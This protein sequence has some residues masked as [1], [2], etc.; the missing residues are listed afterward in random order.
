MSAAT[1]Q[2][3]LVDALG[4]NYEGGLEAIDDALRVDSIILEKKCKNCCFGD[5]DG[6]FNDYDTDDD[7]DDG[8]EDDNK[9]ASLRR[10]SV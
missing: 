4:V 7:Y 2:T 9:R 10:A 1:L 5:V 6:F 3:S 8:E